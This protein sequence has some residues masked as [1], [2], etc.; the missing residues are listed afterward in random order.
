MKLA[1]IIGCVGLILF[2]CVRKI[3][4]RRFAGRK[5]TTVVTTVETSKVQG[6]K[7]VEGVP[8]AAAVRVVEERFRGHSDYRRKGHSGAPF[9]RTSRRTYWVGQVSVFGF[10]VAVERPD[11]GELYGVVKCVGASGETVY[12]VASYPGPDEDEPEKTLPQ[13]NVVVTAL[14]GEGL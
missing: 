2:L 8:A 10:V 4:Y 5:E 6:G 13:S 1:L 12:V 7:T 3:Y 9:L 14:K 11:L